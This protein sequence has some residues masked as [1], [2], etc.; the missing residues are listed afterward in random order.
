MIQV[1]QRQPLDEDARHSKWHSIC[2]L[3][4]SDCRWPLYT[5]SWSSVTGLIAVG[6]GDNAIRIYRIACADAQASLEL[7]ATQLGAHEQDVNCVAWHPEDPTML[8]SAG[9]DAMVKLW[10][11]EQ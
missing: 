4:I 2:R 7:V 1:W 8:A 6:S 5:V 9:D 3:P 10:T 11:V